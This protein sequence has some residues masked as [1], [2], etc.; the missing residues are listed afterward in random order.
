MNNFNVIKKDGKLEAWNDSKIEVAIQ[1]SANRTSVPLSE[2]DV[3][4]VIILV[5]NWVKGGGKDVEVEMLH[6][7]V[8]KALKAVRPDVAEAYDTYHLYRKEVV[9]MWDETRKKAN[10]VIYVGDREN[11][12]FNSTL[13]STQGSLVRGYLTQSLYKQNHLSSVERAGIETGFIYIHD[14]RDLIFNGVN[15]MLFDMGAVLKGGFNMAGLKYKEPKSI[16]SALQVVGDVTLVATAQQFGGFTIPQIDEIMVPYA[17]KS[18]EYHKQEAAKWGIKDDEK[19]AMEKLVEEIRQGFQSFEMKLNSVPCSRGDTA[20]VTISFGCVDSSKG[21]LEKRIQRLICHCILDNRM[22]G[23][24][25]GSPV[26]FPKLVYL[27]SAEQHKEEEQEKLFTHAIECSRTSMYPDYLSLDNGYTGQVFKRS[28]KVVSP[29]GCRAFLSAYYDEDGQEYYTGR[30]NIGAV[31]L[32][33]PM[34]YQYS[35]QSSLDFFDEITKWLEVIRTFHK[36]RY[37]AIAN[38]LAST[39]PLSF[40]QG[41]IKGGNLAPTDKIGFDIVKSFTASFGITSLNELN[42]LHEQKQLHESDQIFIKK[43]VS[44]ISDKVDGF[45][46]EDGY[47]YALYAT[48]AESLAGKQ[49]NQFRKMFGVIEGVSD[50]EYFSNGFHCHVSAPISPFE[51]QDKEQDLFNMIPGGH[52]QYVRLDNPANH[53]AIHFIVKRGMEMGFYQGVNYDLV[54]CEKCGWRPKTIQHVCEKC[55]SEDLT[56]ISRVCGYLGIQYT[57]KNTRFNDSKLAE[58][59]DRV[60]M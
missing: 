28:G 6:G 49:L 7:Y 23:Q 30:A 26:V 45:K 54:V 29:M 8:I 50:R 33:L 2:S 10:D 43:V 42:Y 17:L 9:A 55:G 38:T 5:K 24:G 60:S 46:K 48:P 56:V 12:N 52:I 37:N 1:K 47:L 16:L 20:F 59:K 41:G 44:F 19:F 32:N 18:L 51:K 31:S 11:A 39:N 14:L 36:N 21:E 27:H 40:T 13:I 22:K 3:Q 53:E 4:N 57:N 25:E 15:C 34:I 35:K 58:C